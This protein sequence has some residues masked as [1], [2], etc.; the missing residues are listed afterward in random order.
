MDVVYFFLDQLIFVTQEMTSDASLPK[1]DDLLCAATV[2]LL[3]LQRDQ[4]L[5]CTTGRSLMAAIAMQSSSVMLD[6]F[7]TELKSRFLDKHVPNLR[8]S[9]FVPS[10]GLLPL[11]DVTDSEDEDELPVLPPPQTQ[12]RRKTLFAAG[13]S[14]TNEAPTAPEERRKTL[15]PSAAPAEI[16]SNSENDGIATDSIAKQEQPSTDVQPEHSLPTEDHAVLMMR[17]WRIVARAVGLWCI[18]FELHS[19]DLAAKRALSVSHQE[20]PQEMAP[21]S[22]EVPQPPE[23]QAPTD[24]LAAAEIVKIEEQ[25]PVPRPLSKQTKISKLPPSPS[26]SMGTKAPTIRESNESPMSAMRSLS[27]NAA[28]PEVADCQNAEDLVKL[29]MDRMDRGKTTQSTTLHFEQCLVN[30]LRMLPKKCQTK[31][32]ELDKSAVGSRI[33]CHDGHYLRP[34]FHF[35]VSDVTSMKS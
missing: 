32:S 1:F 28:P 30:H 34:I 6:T 20:S 11:Y 2:S 5:A 15:V 25:T 13:T 8:E 21:T 35:E 17:R 22:S 4:L 10:N 7:R 3:V 26:K 16:N 33:V 24:A 14:T 12:S 19:R 29:F 9:M 23:K 31:T 27:A 18:Y